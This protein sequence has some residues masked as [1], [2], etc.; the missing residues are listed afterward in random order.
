MAGMSSIM[1]ACF[2]ISLC[3]VQQL[4]SAKLLP[5]EGQFEQPAG[6][7]LKGHQAGRPT[8]AAAV[9]L[10]LT[11]K[12]LLVL[13]PHYGEELNHRFRASF[14]VPACMKKKDFC[15]LDSWYESFD[16]RCF[17]ILPTTD[18]FKCL[19]WLFL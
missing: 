2:F 8:A 15:P 16:H 6:G 19:L 14:I 18:Y 3:R 5:S 13:D 17:H 10:V 9:A 11:E 7:H 12:P 1:F 4:P